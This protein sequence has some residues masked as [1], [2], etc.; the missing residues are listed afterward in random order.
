MTAVL[1]I[2]RRELGGYF[3]TMTGYIIA[4]IML[5]LGGLLGLV[6]VVVAIAANGYRVAGILAV[7]R[8]AA[9]DRRPHRHRGG[10]TPCWPTPRA[11]GSSPSFDWPISGAAAP[12]GSPK[13]ALRRAPPFTST[14]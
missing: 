10:D 2:A 5:M 12:M 14:S 13:A 1:L 7:Q 3:R 6:V 9:S 11:R 4:G 8:R